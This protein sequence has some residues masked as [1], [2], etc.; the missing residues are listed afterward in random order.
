MSCPYDM[1]IR[2]SQTLIRAVHC[3]YDLRKVVSDIKSSKCKQQTAVNSLF[4]KV[5]QE[6]IF[7]TDDTR[8]PN[9]QNCVSKSSQSA[10]YRNWIDCNPFIFGSI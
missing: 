4:A 9:Y 2:C 6:R 3:L 5:N 7:E 8:L 1:R 10:R